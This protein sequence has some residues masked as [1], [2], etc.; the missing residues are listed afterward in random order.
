MK[1]ELEDCGFV[2]IESSVRF[3]FKKFLLLNNNNNYQKKKKKW[4]NKCFNNLVYGRENEKLHP[5]SRYAILKN[6]I[7][8][9]IIYSLKNT[10]NSWGTL[11]LF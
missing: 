4:I 6:I 10:F 8:I 11:E 7:I 1:M 5:S 9:I 3:A 2:E